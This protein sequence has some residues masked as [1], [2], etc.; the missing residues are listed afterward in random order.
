MYTL[1]NALIIN[2][3]VV[4]ALLLCALLYLMSFIPFIHYFKTKGRP[5]LIDWMRIVLFSSIVMDFM[6]TVNESNG[7]TTIFFIDNITTDLTDA[8]FVLFTL[9]IAFLSLE[10]GHQGF[11]LVSRYYT[12]P[13]RIGNLGSF[14]LK[15]KKKL[16]FFLAVST[17]FQIY[18]QITGIAGYGSS[19]EYTTGIFSFIKNIQGNFNQIILILTCYVVFVE[20]YKNPKFKNFFY[21][22]LIIQAIMGL[23]SGMKENFLLPILYASVAFIIG[24]GR[25]K[26]SF[27][28]VGFGI[29]ILLYPLNNSY[30]NIINDPFLNKGNSMVNIVLAIENIQQDPLSKTLLGGVESYSARSSMYGYLDNSIKT[31]TNWNYYKNMNRYWAIPLVWLIPRSFWPEKPRSDVG[32]IYNDIL[33]GRTT[34]SITPMNVGWSYFEGGIV[35]VLIIFVLMGI[36]FSKIDYSNIQKPIVFFFYIWSL[37]QVIKP[38]WDP[39]FMFSSAI[40]SFVLCWL[41]IKITKVN[42]RI[43]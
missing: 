6:K 1:N 7:K 36:F 24:G 38:E 27:V 21:I 19:I 3:A 32:A 4:K 26:K 31:E 5:R 12:I 34:N 30:R 9:I 28:I 10:I 20:R 33:V 13:K 16:I 18:F 42:I 15:G 11:E 23:L 25:V 41:T 35:F 37:H 8:P 14:K 43:G 2:I 22:L 17:I 40:Q 39:Y 29:L